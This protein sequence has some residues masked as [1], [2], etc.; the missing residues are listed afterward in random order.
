MSAG[1]IY[2]WET[3]QAKG[4]DLRWKY[5]VYLGEGNWRADGFA[6]MFISKADYGGDYEIRKTDYDFLKYEVS[7]V[8]CSSLVFYT[9]EELAAAK[10][11]LVG[12]L[13]TEHLTE[14]YGKV[15]ESDY[16]EGWQIKLA[17][18]T[19]KKTIDG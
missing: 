14:L 13:S 6:F 16:M 2:Y 8:S 15:S 1:R 3:D 4:H 5:H 10:P 9:Q 19:L 18:E 17:C 11:K 7:Y 12:T